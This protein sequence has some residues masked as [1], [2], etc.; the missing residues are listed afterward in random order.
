MSLKSTFLAFKKSCTSCP[1]W[2]RGRGGNLD[3]IQKKSNFFRETVPKYVKYNWIAASVIS[4]HHDDHQ[5]KE[6]HDKK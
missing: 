3:K 6:Y 5:T 1:N 4:C 2:G